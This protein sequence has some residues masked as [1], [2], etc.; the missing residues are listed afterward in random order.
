MYVKLFAN[1]VRW[2]PWIAKKP[3]R[4]INLH[5]VLELCPPP[6]LWVRSKSTRREGTPRRHEPQ[7][8]RHES[9]RFAR[10]TKPPLYNKRS[11]PPTQHRF[12]KFCY[13]LIVMIRNI[14]RLIKLSI[15]FILKLWNFLTQK[16]RYLEK[17]FC[18][19][20]SLFCCNLWFK[21]YLFLKNVKI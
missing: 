13:I 4:F 12:L 1:W 3:D 7:L 18:N 5:F 17:Y 6:L 14:Y 20:F 10:Q 8:C 21:Q 9:P 19:K 15:R 16:G 11:P 2:M